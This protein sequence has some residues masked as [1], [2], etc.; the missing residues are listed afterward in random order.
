MLC[1]FLPTPRFDNTTNPFLS[2]VEIAPVVG[3]VS[4]V[5]PLLRCHVILWH[6]RVASVGFTCEDQLKRQYAT[7]PKEFPVQ[8]LLRNSR[9]FHPP[10]NFVHVSVLAFYL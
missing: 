10:W 9:S 8:L 1:D 7:T 6:R 3:A 5:Y 2:G 4:Q